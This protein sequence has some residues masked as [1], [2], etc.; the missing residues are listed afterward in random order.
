MQPTIQVENVQFPDEAPGA[1]REPDVGCAFYLILLPCTKCPP[2]NCSIACR[3]HPGME[4]R[5]EGQHF[6]HGPQRRYRDAT[7]EEIED[8]RANVWGWDGDRAVPSLTPSFLGVEKDKKG[9][10]IRPYR[11]HSYLT[12]G[13]L[14][15]LSDSTVILHP[16]PRPCVSD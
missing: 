13:K 6:W 10:V 12:R 16:D 3:T 8:D 2:P 4:H 1:F 14:D 7:P 15:V 5:Y 11:L 9:R